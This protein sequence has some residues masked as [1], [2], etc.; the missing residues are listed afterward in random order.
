METHHFYF[1]PFIRSNHWLRLQLSNPTYGGSAAYMDK[2]EAHSTLVISRNKEFWGDQGAQNDILT[3]NGIN[4]I[5]AATCPVVKGAYR[6][7]VIGI[8]AYDKGADGI[9]DLA[10]PIPYFYSVSFMSG[11]DVVIPAASP[12][13]ATTSAVL[14]P[15][16]G[17]GA[18]QVINFPNWVSSTDR[19]S[20]LFND[21]VDSRCNQKWSAH[22]MPGKDC[23]RW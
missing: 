11:V 8:Y 9:T 23:G 18:L 20:I 4:I 7:G 15:R 19:I 12:A 5:N 17:C 6:T 21:F 22:Q 16:G 10:A 14:M 1:Q 13:N 3:L 2:G